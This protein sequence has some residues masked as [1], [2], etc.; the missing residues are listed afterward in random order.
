MSVSTSATGKAL[1]V[2]I[3]PG[4]VITRDFDDGLVKRARSDG[5]MYVESTGCIVAD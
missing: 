2:E 1:D 5:T 4:T 3:V